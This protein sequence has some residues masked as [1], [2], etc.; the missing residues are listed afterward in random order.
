MPEI[1]DLC[2]VDLNMAGIDRVGVHH[3]S[4][5]DMRLGAV[6]MPLATV[7][8]LRSQMRVRRRTLSRHEGGQEYE[9]PSGADALPD[10]V[11][12]GSGWIGFSEGIRT[13]LI[14][15][16]EFNASADPAG[17]PMAAVN[18]RGLEDFDFSSIPVKHYD[19]RSL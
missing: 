17:N 5:M 3:R 10:H 6:P 8:V 4:L 13:S 12:I 15:T 16:S 9:A 19:G 1:D 2:F 11:D 7:V 18:V 14:I